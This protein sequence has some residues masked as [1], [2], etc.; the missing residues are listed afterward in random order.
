MLNNTKYEITNTEHIEYPWLHRIRALRPVGVQVQA[1]ELGGFVESEDNLSFEPGDD[2]W[3]FDDAIACGN[4]R[5]RK[6]GELHDE[7]I[8]RDSALVM[9]QSVLSGHAVVEDEAMVRAATVTENAHVS[10]F[11]VVAAMPNTHSRPL[12]AANAV[13]YGSIYGGFGIGKDAVILPGEKL[14]NNTPDTMCLRGS[15]R[16]VRRSKERCGLRNVPVPPGYVWQ[17]ISKTEIRAAN[18]RL[19]TAEKG[20]RS[21]YEQSDYV[22]DPHQLVELSWR[23]AEAAIRLGIRIGIASD[24]EDYHGSHE[25]EYSY[26]SITSSERL[27]A[28]R[29]N[30]ELCY[31]Q[32]KP[33]IDPAYER[34][35]TGLSPKRLKQTC[36]LELEGSPERTMPPSSRNKPKGKKTRDRSR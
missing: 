26:S 24:I 15:E 33:S 16:T 1:G 28:E 20:C 10:G 34:A 27:E 17:P 25:G 12:L 9:E 29:K 6:G 8:A 4:A 21:A 30:A 11:G 36:R 13:V 5:V 14:D 23:E 19:D 3:V 22:S 2:A 18:I 7:A 31:S 35:E 32:R